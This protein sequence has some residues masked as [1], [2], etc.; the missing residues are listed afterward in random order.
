[1]RTTVHVIRN[2][3]MGIVI[4][5]AIGAAAGIWTRPGDEQP[6]IRDVGVSPSK[7]AGAA[8]RRTNGAGAG[9]GTPRTQPSR[10]ASIPPAA[11]APPSAE[12]AHADQSIQSA[13]RAVPKAAPE[14]EPAA[15]AAPAAD[16]V[17]AGESIGHADQTIQP[18]RGEETK[19][20][21]QREPAPRDGL[22]AAPEPDLARAR[23][24]AD[25][26]DVKGLMA[27]RDAVVRRA[28]ASGEQQSP[29][30]KQQL[31]QL[32]RYLADAR[33]LRLRLDAQELR[34]ALD[35]R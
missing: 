30:V 25:R 21:P 32:D 7:P 10:E 27:L 15:I 29:A 5:T 35:K 8:S 12:R 19:A 14:R 4:G 22:A 18:A 13:P 1:M 31:D 24:L 34:K 2:G 17:S 9:S 33:A 3:L 6:A 23:S 26:A 20:V 28:Q 11:V 16:R